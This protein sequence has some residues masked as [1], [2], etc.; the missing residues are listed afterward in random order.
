M[1]VEFFVPGIPVTKGSK[2]GFVVPR[3]GAHPMVVRGLKHYLLRDVQVVMTEQ[4]K[5][6]LAPWMQQIRAECCKVRSGPLWDMAVELELTFMF[7][8]PKGDFGTGRNAGTLKAS[9]PRYKITRPDLD[10]VERAVKDALTGVLYVDDSVVVKTTKEKKFDSHY[11]GVMIRA[12]T[13][14]DDL[15]LDRPL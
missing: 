7:P 2:S 3:R 13:M 14:S 9:A 10:K 12:R 8:R 11:P 4:A 6:R 5:D 15:G 1:E